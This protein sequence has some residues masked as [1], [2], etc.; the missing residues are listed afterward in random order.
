V[1][2]QTD[3]YHSSNIGPKSVAVLRKLLEGLPKQKRFPVYDLYRVFVNHPMCTQ[4]FQGSDGGAHW[5]QYLISALEDTECHKATP[6][7]CL[8]A[9]C[10]LFKH[11]ATLHMVQQRRET[12]M[13]AAAQYVYSEDKN[14][15]AAA[16][17]LFLNYSVIG[18][19]KTDFEGSV[20]S[21]GCL[22]ERIPEEKEIDVMYRMVLTCGNL[23]DTNAD[24]KQMI[25]DLDFK[26]P[27][28]NTLS[29]GGA[30]D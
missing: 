15:R 18:I 8:R 4:V 20:Q 1:L 24:T 19:Q 27:A 30:T 7:L 6:M 29:N 14:V 16:T 25:K 12:I 9:L 3:A 10:N 2:T 5:L 21:A 26:I 23:M 22:S 28:I 13:N 17:S 11:G